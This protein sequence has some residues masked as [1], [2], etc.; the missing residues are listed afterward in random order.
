[1]EIFIERKNTTKHI[2]LKQPIQLKEVLKNLK[3]TN[4][5]VILVKNDEV[6]LESELINDNDKLKILSVVSGGK[7]AKTTTNLKHIL[8]KLINSLL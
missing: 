5:S 3:I 1:M 2:K 8:S 7:P 6:C 4:N